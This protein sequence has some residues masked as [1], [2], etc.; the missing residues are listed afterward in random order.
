MLTLK[1]LTRGERLVLERRRQGQTQRE[2][3]KRLNVARYT[4]RGW[5]WDEIGGAPLTPL[6]KLEPIEVAYILRRREEISLGDCAE[7]MGVS[8]W[9]F[10]RMERGDVNPKRLLRYWG[11]AA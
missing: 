4:Y 7:N 8:K 2:A 6:G 5:E 1:K 10:R 9:W 11:I 3:A